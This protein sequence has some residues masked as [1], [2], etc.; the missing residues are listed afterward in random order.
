M[1]KILVLLCIIVIGLIR[2]L[3]SKKHNKES[4]FLLV[5]LFI[6]IVPFAYGKAI[7]TFLEGQKI[8]QVNNVILGPF[9]NSVRIEAPLVF[10]ILLMLLGFTHLRFK[11]FDIKTNLWFYLLIILCIIT[12]INPNSQFN[13]SFLPLISLISQVLLLFKVIE[14]NF[15]RRE[16]ITGLYDGLKIVSLIQFVLTVFYPLLGIEAAAS[17]FRGEEALEWAQRRASASAIGTFGH[18]GTLALFSLLSAVFFTSCYLNKY[19]QKISKYMIM[20]NL[21]VIFFTLSRTTYLCTFG[22][23]LLLLVVKTQGKGLFRIKNLVIFV[24]TFSIILFILYLTPLS[25]MFLESDANDQFENRFAHWV[26]GYQMWSKSKFIGV[27]I[28]SHV[29]YMI[30]KLF[31]T[32]DSPIVAFLIRSPIHNIH[33]IVLAETGILGFLSWLYFYISRLAKYSKHCTGENSI[34]NILNLSFVGILCSFFLYGFLGWSPFRVEILVLGLFIAYFAKV[35]VR[36][37]Q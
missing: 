26:L 4:N 32:I 10:A 7:Y 14:W 35:Q 24:I 29:Y 34:N 31:I 21:F 16:I 36:T 37:K 15:S 19:E 27:G 30:N 17:I 23:L 5:S 22:I 13:L 18:P 33:M 25:N 12:F 8:D 6:Q 20:A 28:N 9:G 2:W 1:I 3:I 11:A